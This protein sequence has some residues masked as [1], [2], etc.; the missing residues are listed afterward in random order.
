MDSFGDHALLC[1]RD[2]SSAGFQLRHRLVQQTLS[3]LL[4]QAGIT[5]AVEPQHL[6]LSRDEGPESGLGSGLTRPADIL[7]YGWRDDRHCCVDLVGVCP[8]RG[9]WRDAVSVLSVVEQA[10]RDKHVDTCASHRFDFVPFGFSV[11]GSFGPAAQELLDRICRRYRTHARIA[12]WEAHA[13]VHRRLSFTVMR[14]VA[15]QFV[16]RHLASFGW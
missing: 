15:E 7:L 3:T 2:P 6:R 8:A 1:R 11:L 9:G 16:G 10:K 5:H 4:R 13:R 12:E 14:G